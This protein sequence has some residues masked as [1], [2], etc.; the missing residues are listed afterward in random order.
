MANLVVTLV[1]PDHPGI[2]ESVAQ[3]IAAHGGNWLESRMAHL[4]GKFA[5]ILRIEVAPAS[6]AGLVQALA[7]LERHGLKVVVEASEPEGEAAQGRYLEL[8]LVGTD[9]PGIVREISHVLVAHGV[10]IEELTTDRPAAAMSGAPL[11]RA[12]ARV[13]PPPQADLRAL[14]AQLEKV[15]VDLMVEVKLVEPRRE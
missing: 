7:A 13:R 10:N 11:F 2:V 14:R 15:A 4:A 9:R 6:Q 5:G 1:G 3:P 8:D 12:H